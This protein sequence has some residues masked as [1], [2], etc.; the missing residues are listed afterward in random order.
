M[1]RGRQ[2][3]VAG[4]HRSGRVSRHL[5]LVAGYLLPGRNLLK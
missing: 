3:D 5:W 4:R 1:L 2:G